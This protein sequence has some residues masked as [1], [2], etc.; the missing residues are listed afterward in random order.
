MT[1][2]SV[3]CHPTPA[4]DLPKLVFSSEAVWMSLGALERKVVE[5]EGVQSRKALGLL[6]VFAKDTGVPIPKV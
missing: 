5:A 2:P 4:L 1:E 6:L 3:T